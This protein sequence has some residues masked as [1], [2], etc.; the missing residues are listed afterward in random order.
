MKCEY[1]YCIYNSGNE[2]MF[3]EVTINNLGMCDDCIIIS[4][5][6]EFL[7]TKKKQQLEAID[8]RWKNEDK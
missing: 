6:K 4:L 3:E 7:E 1:E 5:D 8:R 2:C